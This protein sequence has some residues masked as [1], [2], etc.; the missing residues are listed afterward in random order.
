MKGTPKIKN[1][2]VPRLDPLVL[3]AALEYY[4]RG[5][6]IIPIAKGTKKPPKGWPWK[7]YQ[8]RKP[9]EDE[10][11]DWFYLRD[12]LC[13]AVILG[14]VSGGLVCRDFDDMAAYEAW[15][16]RFPSLAATLP[17]VET[18]RGRH[19]YFLAECD[20]I[21]HLDDGELRG[22]GY[23]LLP[24]SLHPD[25]HVYEWLI[26]LPQGHL[27]FVSD[28]Q[29]AGFLR[30]DAVTERTE[31][32][33]RTDDCRGEPRQLL[34][35]SVE[36]DI[37]AAILCSLPLQIGTRNRQVFEL[38]RALK[39]IPSLADAPVDSLECHVRR[40][41]T[42]GIEKRVIG[43]EPFE[44][45]WIDF[46]LGWP[47][48]RFP[49][50]SEPMARLLELAKSAPL[51]TAAM[52]YEQ[53][54][55]RLLVALCRELQGVSGDNPFFLSCRTAAEL[56]ELTTSKGLPDHIKAWR[57]LFLLVQD[58]VLTEVEKGDIKGRRATRFRYL[59]D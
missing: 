40:W 48:V 30:L 57:W 31:T 42:L 22:A 19:V 44:E 25:G 10:L 7:P 6:A 23:C 11:R 41:H 35:R 9:T 27:P 56:L 34:G 38:A 16:A 4:R 14:P 3:E 43:T 21:T 1:R 13:L 53:E 39:A 46:T 49:K 52:G 47:K 5:W 45:T 8:T 32:T 33:E 50:G 37:E 2:Q 55:L 26:P 20:R 58:R 29:T 12:D 15:A 17:T 28:V 18:A 24:P 59:G 54:S 51:P 36:A